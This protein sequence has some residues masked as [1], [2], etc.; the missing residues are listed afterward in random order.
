[1]FGIHF[2]ESVPTNYREWRVTRS[3][4]Y[5]KFAWG[6]I[7]RGFMLEPDSRE[8][9]FICEAHQNIDLNQLADAAGQSLQAALK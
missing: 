2:S 4:L 5:R 1:M 9:W 3:D 6:L 7:E 8:P